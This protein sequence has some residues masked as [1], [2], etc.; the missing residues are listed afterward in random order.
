[1]AGSTLTDPDTDKNNPGQ[2]HW[3]DET[4]RFLNSNEERHDGSSLSDEDNRQI[5]NLEDSFRA[6]SIGDGDRNTS[7]GDWRTNLDKSDKSKNKGKAKTPFGKR[8]KLLTGLGV[9]GGAAA[10][11]AIVMM[12]LPLKL[13]MFIQNITKTTKP[14]K[15]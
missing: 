2:K 7:G 3:H 15:K 8:K 14:I 6:P 10:I 13:E 11:I 4:S 1:M 5:G 9:G 12:L